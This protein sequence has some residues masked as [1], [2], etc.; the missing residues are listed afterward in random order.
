[1]DNLKLIDRFLES[2]DVGYGADYRDPDNPYIFVSVET[3][4]SIL[5]FVRSKVKEMN[6]KMRKRGNYYIIT[7]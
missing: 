5:K 3:S 6:L 4:K 2:L 1:M 7:A